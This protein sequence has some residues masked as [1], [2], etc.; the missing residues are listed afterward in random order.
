MADELDP[1]ARRAEK[2]ADMGEGP[3]QGMLTST[4]GRA[5]VIFAELCPDASERAAILARQQA[6]GVAKYGVTVSSANLTADQWR[7][8]A[9]QE[10]ADLLVYLIAESESRRKDAGNG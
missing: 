4:A 7:E 9:K 3:F 2:L 8:H 10:A 6:K 1:I 5:A